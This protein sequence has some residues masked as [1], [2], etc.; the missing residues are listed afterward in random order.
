[1]N[2]PSSG[3]RANNW[4]LSVEDEWQAVDFLEAR[5]SSK[6]SRSTFQGD[7]SARPKS[8]PQVIKKG[9]FE[10]AGLT[11][12]LNCQIRKFG[13]NQDFSLGQEVYL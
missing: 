5:F 2:P 13:F 9:V 4:K 8:G 12:F 10:I 11:K 1:M 3:M 7:F 6:T